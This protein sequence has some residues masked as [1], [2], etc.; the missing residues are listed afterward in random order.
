MI[1]VMI[2][3]VIF[4]DK[5]YSLLEVVSVVVIAIGLIGISMSDKFAENAFDALGI[6]AVVL[7]LVCDAVAVNLEEK[8]FSSYGATQPEVIFML[9]SIGT[10]FLGIPGLILNDI[11]AGIAECATEPKVLVAILILAASGAVGVEFI[12]LIIKKFGSLLVTMITSLRKGFTVVISFVAFGN[13]KFTLWH[14]VSIGCVFAGIGLNVLAR[15]KPKEEPDVE[16]EP[17]PNDKDNL[18]STTE[19]PLPE[20]EGSGSA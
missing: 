5:R 11:P 20:E 1:P 8:A 12:F 18:L 6:M 9:Y 16:S 10:P 15:R 17:V 4:L 7:S 3:G 2:G 14:G 13:K 19:P